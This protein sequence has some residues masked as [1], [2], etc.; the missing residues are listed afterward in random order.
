M[1]KLRWLIMRRELWLYVECSYFPVAMQHCCL[2]ISILRTPSFSALRGSREK[3]ETRFGFVGWRSTLNCQQN[4]GCA[5]FYVFLNT[6]M[7]VCGFLW[8]HGISQG[9]LD[10]SGDR[11]SPVSRSTCYGSLCAGAR[12]QTILCLSPL[13]WC[14]FERCLRHRSKASPSISEKWFPDLIWI[15]LPACLVNLCFSAVCFQIWCHGPVKRINTRVYTERL[16]VR[17]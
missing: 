14:S 1:A 11:R 8:Q 5:L 15:G 13:S 17:M 7:H 9:P 2:I 6:R 3:L 4:M 12:P 16:S 10:S